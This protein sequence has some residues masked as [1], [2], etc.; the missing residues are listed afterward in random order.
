MKLRFITSALLAGAMLLSVGCNKEKNEPETPTDPYL[1]YK[2]LDV[3]A[4]NVKEIAY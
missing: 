2:N 1:G 4:G 3:K